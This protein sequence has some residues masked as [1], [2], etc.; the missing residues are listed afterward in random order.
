M[1]RIILTC[2][3]IL[4]VG[5]QAKPSGQVVKIKN[6]LLLIK[7]SE[8][9][10]NK[11]DLITI[12][13]QTGK[14]TLKIGTAKIVKIQGNQV[15]AKILSQK[16]GVSIATGD[17]IGE[18]KSDAVGMNTYTPSE[19]AMTGGN[20]TP[21]ELMLIQAWPAFPENQDRSTTSLEKMLTGIMYQE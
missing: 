20:G 4:A 14:G 9:I 17:F 21:V 10:G 16:K 8:S 2:L 7:C 11:N 3:L 18:D 1:K 12:K 6:S 15:V 19:Q 13:R 5:L